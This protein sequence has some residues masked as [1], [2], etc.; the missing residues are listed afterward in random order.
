M[1]P[2]RSIPILVTFVMSRQCGYV[3]RGASTTGGQQTMSDEM[4]AW[5]SE[6]LLYTTPNGDVRVEVFYQAET[7]W[8]NQRRMAELFA[9][10]NPTHN[11]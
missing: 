7:F 1:A 6:I 10:L 5:E 3:S 9:V 8:L 11:L 2:A 4:I